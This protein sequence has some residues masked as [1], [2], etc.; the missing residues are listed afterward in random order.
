[1]YRH[2]SKLRIDSTMLWCF[3]VWNVELELPSRVRL[4]I[5]YSTSRFM[6]PPFFLLIL[7]R[8]QQ[9]DILKEKLSSLWRAFE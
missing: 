7:P 2:D 3:D 5:K 8:S 4:G 1:M 6:G 9:R